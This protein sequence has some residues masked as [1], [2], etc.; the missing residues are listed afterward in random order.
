[1]LC[2]RPPMPECHRSG[3]G[4]TVCNRLYCNCNIVSFGGRCVASHSALLAASLLA[5]FVAMTRT[6]GG[7]LLQAHPTFWVTIECLPAG[8][9]IHIQVQ[10]RKLC[11]PAP[12][13]DSAAPVEDY[14]RVELQSSS[15]FARFG[16]SGPQPRS[17][18]QRTLP[19]PARA[20]SGTGTKSARRPP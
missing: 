2:L 11:L 16:P 7:E 1:M 20:K 4:T 14:V 13:S 3:G 10:Q 6:L 17:P 5:K 15:L 9:A 19:P 18:G 8:S 12:P